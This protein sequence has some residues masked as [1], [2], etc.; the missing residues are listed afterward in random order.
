MKLDKIN[1]IIY[2]VEEIWC[3]LK[4]HK[5]RNMLTGFGIS[6]GIFILVLLVGAGNG[7]QKGVMILFQDYSQNSF[8]VYGGKTSIV[9]TGQKANQEIF[10]DKQDLNQLKKWFP[11]I[12]TTSWEMPYS[13][14]YLHSNKNSYHRF[15]CLGVESNYF[16]IKTFATSSGR[17]FNP[18]DDQS[19]K[20]IAIIGENIADA[21]F[22]TQNVLGKYLCLDNEWFQ[23]IG[24]LESKSLFSDNKNKIFLPFSFV[25]KTLQHSQKLQT[26]AFSLH[27]DISASR[28]EK[29]LLGYLA[30]KYHFNQKDKNAI[31]INNI[32][33]NSKA[34]KGLFGTINSFLWMVGFC[35]LLS[36][37]VGVSNIMLVVVKERTQEIGIRKAIGATP[38]SILHMILN[39]SIIITLL[40]G[41]T[42]L[43]SASVIVYFINFLIGDMIADKNSIFKGLNVN[44]PIAIGAII[45]LVIAGALAGLYPA[46]KAASVL[47]I[48]AIS[49][50][51]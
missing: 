19:G 29:N 45:T 34:L 2:Q 41:I 22:S 1:N 27:Q 33:A 49:E 51:H 8:W 14:K 35:M 16:K 7:L 17:L 20:K 13:A 32:Q 15:E 24:V 36:G 39:E 30:R 10:F 47:P 21:L 31:Y 5:R 44:I 12:I 18:L 3:S 28:F 42:G 38:K 48:K 37:I 40:S 25:H 11:E 4:E 50:D 23:I 26:Y 43:L 6:W 9:Q 46:R